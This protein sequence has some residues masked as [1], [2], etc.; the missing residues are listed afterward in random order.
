MKPRNVT[1]LNPRS[2]CSRISRGVFNYLFHTWLEWGKWWHGG[3]GDSKSRHQS[4][5]LVM[6]HPTDTEGQPA[7]LFLSSLANS[8][9]CLLA[10][11]RAEAAHLP[12]PSLVLTQTTEW[13]EIYILPN[14]PAWHQLT[15]LKET[16]RCLQREDWDVFFERL[17]SRPARQPGSR[18]QMATLVKRSRGQGV[19]LCTERGPRAPIPFLLHQTIKTS[20]SGV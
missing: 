15:L 4:G 14:R 20:Q 19:N 10:H 6:S 12:L 9:K 11:Q 16:R 5:Q 7:V 13:I 8:A 18:W 3:H 1:N 2:G 17:F